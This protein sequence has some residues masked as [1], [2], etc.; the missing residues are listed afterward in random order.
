MQTDS[1]NLIGHDIGECCISW[2]LVEEIKKYFTT[3]ESANYT[4]L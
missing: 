2:E 3:Y 4:Y 1:K